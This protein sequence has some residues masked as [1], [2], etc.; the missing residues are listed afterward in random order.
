M[1]GEGNLKIVLANE[2]Y[3]CNFANHEMALFAPSIGV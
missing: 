1:L 3:L 2:F